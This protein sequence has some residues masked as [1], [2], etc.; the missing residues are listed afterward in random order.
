M[1]Y[2]QI[3]ILRLVRRCMSCSGS[4]SYGA[5]VLK[6]FTKLYLG[7]QLGYCEPDPKTR[8]TLSPLE[9]TDRQICRQ[10]YY[11]LYWFYDNHVCICIISFLFH[12]Y[13]YSVPAF[14][15]E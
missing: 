5:K 1:Q 12:F 3:V 10:Q 13:Y 14:C 9:S 8:Q 2:F 6:S 11:E 7:H 15:V 4:A